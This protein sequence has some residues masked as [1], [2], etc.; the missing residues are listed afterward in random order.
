MLKGELSLL[1]SSYRDLEVSSGPPNGLEWPFLFCFCAFPLTSQRQVRPPSVLTACACD[2][3]KARPCEQAGTGTK[4]PSTPPPHC[5]P[6]QQWGPQHGTRIV[7]AHCG[8]TA[9]TP[10][11]QPRT[12][13]RRPPV[14]HSAADGRGTQLLWESQAG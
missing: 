1:A 13:Q 5:P 2:R 12:A 8:S 6:G 4:A 10:R 11:P 3:G 9:G 14:L 7:L